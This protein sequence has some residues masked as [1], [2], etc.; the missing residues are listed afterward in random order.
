M[1]SYGSK[2]PVGVR[3]KEVVARGGAL[4]VTVSCLAC[5]AEEKVCAD[6]KLEQELWIPR[7]LVGFGSS[8]GCQRS[9]RELLEAVRS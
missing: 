4:V 9:P 1:A 6:C 8:G 7:A 2:A 5:V 3:L